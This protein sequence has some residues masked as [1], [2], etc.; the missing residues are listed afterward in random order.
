MLS[1]ISIW[2]LVDEVHELV[3][4]RSDNYLCAAVALLTHLGTVG[5][6]RIILAA[7]TCGKTLRV[8]AI[9]VLQELH[10]A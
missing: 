1:I 6:Q 5:C 3:E 8:N 10:Y 4:F 7:A 9:A 2:S